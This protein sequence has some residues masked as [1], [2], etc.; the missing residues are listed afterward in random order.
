MKRT[1][2]VDLVRNTFI[3]VNK[4][5]IR[6]LKSKERQKYLRKIAKEGVKNDNKNSRKDI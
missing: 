5:V 6:S 1:L 4:L 3:D 2:V